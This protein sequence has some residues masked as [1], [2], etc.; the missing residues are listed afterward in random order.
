MNVLE[1]IS[2]NIEEV[3]CQS[4]AR[5]DKTFDICRF[6][7]FM[8]EGAVFRRAHRHNYYMMLVTT[9]GRGSQ[10]IDFRSFPVRP[11]RVFLMYPGMIHAWEADEGLEGYLIFFT[12]EFFSLRYNTN[13]LLDFPFFNTSYG[14]PY[15]DVPEGEDW[16]RMVQLSNWALRTYE[17]NEADAQL[18]LRSYLNLILLDAQ[19]YYPNQVAGAEA[20]K[21]HHG[22]TLVKTFEQLIDRHFRR[23]RS[24]SG[25]ADMMR[26]TPNYLNTVCKS[27]TG[28]S[29]G[30]LIRHRVMLEAR[31]MLLHENKT[32]AE[33]GHALSFDDNAYFCRF[34]KKYEGLSPD[35]FRKQY[36]QSGA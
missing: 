3:R 2:Y 22:R 27:V 6:E 12:A 11:G 29:A 30:E 8:P 33:V 34:F 10:L 32:V 20:E 1:P 16:E 36:L 18:H 14:Q 17:R 26:L 13:A 21:D 19:R 35:R 24:V 5:G 4:F 28:R 7:D 15:V 25:Y 31:R 23:V 9:A